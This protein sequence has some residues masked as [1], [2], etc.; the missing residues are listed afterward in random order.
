[1]ADNNSFL[2]WESFKHYDAKMDEVII[3][4]Y[5]KLGAGGYVI[6]SSLSETSENAVQNKVI[7]EALENYY[8]KSTGLRDGTTYADIFSTS[9]NSTHG[10]WNKWCIVSGQSNTPDTDGYIENAPEISEALWYEVFTG[11]STDDLVYSRGFQIAIGCYNHQKKIYVRYLHD[12]VWSE[13]YKFANSTD[14]I[15]VN[16]QSQYDCNTLFDAG[17]YLVSRGTNTPP[18]VDCGSLL[19][20][21]YRKPYGNEIP[22]YVAQIFIPTGDYS[23]TSMWYR[24]SIAN[25]FSEW[26]EVLSYD[27][28]GNNFVMYKGQV[29]DVELLNN[30]AYTGAPY[31]CTIN[32]FDATSIGLPAC[33][34]HI[35]YM[36]HSN[37]DG[38]GMQIA[39]PLNGPSQPPRYRTSLGTTWD[40]WK[41]FNDGGNA[42]TL[43]G[44]HAS[45]L[46][47]GSTFT[48]L[49]SSVNECYTAGTYSV[50]AAYTPDYP[51]YGNYGLLDVRCYGSIVYQT[52]RYETG[53][54]INRAAI[55]GQTNWTAWARVN[56]GGNAD[57]VDGLH[58]YQLGTLDASGNSHGT[59]YPLY[60]KYNHFGD[61]RFGL[62]LDTHE[63][64]VNYATNADYAVSA[65]HTYM[66]TASNVCLRNMSSGTAA[67]TTT[68]CPSGAWYGQ[69]D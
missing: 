7:A 59:A 37:G 19:V 39:F 64:R 22:D 1:M 56:D 49:T 51:D 31:E 30:A 17:V 11:G 29:N 26:H 28:I 33:W 8:N 40:A 42:D 65:N 27:N 15:A 9:L 45:E 2:N 52:I 34:W 55:I 69:H 23:K 63:T 53:V 57:T 35:K 60:C 36:R 44:L 61:G 13:W 24:T 68:N 4:I 12:N 20:M 6:D 67:A 21:P 41:N 66:A 10:C 3:D 38:Y 50:A 32:E 5:N 48:Q 54:I 14:G 43:D 47:T 62:T 16:H 25:A 58:A 18:N 46:I